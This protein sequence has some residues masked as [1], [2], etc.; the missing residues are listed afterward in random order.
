MDEFLTYALPVLNYKETENLNRPIIS[1]DTESKISQQR[2]AQPPTRWLN[3]VILLKASGTVLGSF[4]LTL[5]PKTERA[6]SNQFY[7]LSI[8]RKTKATKILPTK[9][10]L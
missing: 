1:K 10:K 9:R 2:K 8:T 3:W 7:E 4:L 6:L 5:S